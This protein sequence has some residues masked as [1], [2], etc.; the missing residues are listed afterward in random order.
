[1]ALFSRRKKTDGV[2]AGGRAGRRRRSRREPAERAGDRRADAAASVGIS[3]SSYQ[4]L[5]ARRPPRPHGRAARR[6]LPARAAARPAHARAAPRPRPRPRR[7][8]ACATTWCCARR[9]PRCPRPPAARPPRRRAPAAAGHLFLRVKGDA[10]A[11]LSEGKDLPLGVAA[12]GGKQF[13][14]AYSSGAALQA[15]VRADGETDTSA[16]GQPVLAVAPARARRPVRRAHPRPRPPRRRARCCRGSC[17]R[18]SSSRPTR[19][20]R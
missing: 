18:S 15:S 2:D 8:P 10:R 16:M 17:S 6:R 9:S 7:C 11:L 14:L 5:G 4:G 12:V 1:M 19:H 20:S 13:V 3:V